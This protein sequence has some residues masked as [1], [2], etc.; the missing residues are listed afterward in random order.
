MTRPKVC[1]A[2]P[3]GVSFAERPALALFVS[4]AILSLVAGAPSLGAQPAHAGTIDLRTHDFSN[5]TV[6]LTGEWLI[7]WEQLLEPRELAGDRSSLA[8]RA[9]GSF[10]MP[11]IWN[12]WEYQGQP[13]GGNGYA[14]FVA[15]ILTPPDAARL[16][17]F[18]PNASTAYR[19]WANGVEVAASGD[20]G[21]TR[22]TTRPHYAMRSTTVEPQSGSINLVLQV[23]NFHH[24]R[25]G[26]WKPIEMGT[27]QQISQRTT[28]EFTYDIM[29]LASFLALVFFNVALTIARPAPSGSRVTPQLLLAIG[30]VAMALRVSVTGQM[31][32]TSLFPG[33]PWGAQLRIEYLSV[34]VVFIV[35]AWICDRVYPGVVPRPV[36]IG[37]TAFVLACSFIV[38][39]FPVIVYSRVVTTYNIVQGLTLLA[40]LV[41]F[42]VWSAKGN[43]R[44][45]VLVGTAAIFFFVTVSETLHY[46]GLVLSRD[47]AP[48]GFLVGLLGGLFENESAL[49]LV[50]TFLVLGTMLVVF[51][52]LVVRVSLLLAR[53][54]GELTPLDTTALAERYGVTAREIEI[55]DLV[56]GGK[57]NKEIGAQLFIAEGTVKNHLHRIMKKIGVGNRT[58]LAM[59]VR[60]RFTQADDQM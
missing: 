13:V 25:G 40:V 34:Q 43:R 37:I 35:F 31:L 27:P 18:V 56:A 41:R 30:F 4:L 2:I 3:N 26:M 9:D 60:P 11:A 53:T 49:Y 54:Q 48:A 50:S 38:V 28:S 33:F 36:I 8:E 51:N 57:S 55:L 39:A 7:F 12:A 5:G 24:R 21:E 17:L 32:V 45:W 58:E 16:A 1:T 10:T 14:T 46:R 6:E 15:T 44:G 42:V 52:L 47:F 23:A 59:R 22:E 29:L 19:L 20:P